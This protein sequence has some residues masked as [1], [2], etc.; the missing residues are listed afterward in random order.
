MSLTRAEI[1]RQINSLTRKKNVCEN[2]RKKYK[3]SLTYATKLVGS[4]SSSRNDLNYSNS[5]MEKYFTINNK[6]ADSGKIIST[7]DELNEMIRKLNHT[8]IPEINNNINM[9]TREIANIERQISSLRR[10]YETAD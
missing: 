10:Q 9:L 8:I 7:R 1:S 3:T 4:L 2:E 6:T 5:N